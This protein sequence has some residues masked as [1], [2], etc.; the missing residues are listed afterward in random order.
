MIFTDNLLITKKTLD[1][2]L[3]E[4]IYQCDRTGY[5]NPVRK[6]E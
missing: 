4:K 2:Q 1:N 5:T 6:K 3:Y